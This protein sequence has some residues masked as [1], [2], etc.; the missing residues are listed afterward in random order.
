MLLVLGDDWAGPAANPPALGG[1]IQTLMDLAARMWTQPVVLIPTC[2][3]GGLVLTASDLAGQVVVDLI[4]HALQRR[5]VAV[6]LVP[7]VL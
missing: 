5:R 3:C 7:N 1:P 4:P 6:R 2:N